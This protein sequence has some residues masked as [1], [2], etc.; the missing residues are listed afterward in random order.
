MLLNFGVA[1]Q[2]QQKIDSRPKDIV[3]GMLGIAPVTGAGQKDEMPSG[4]RGGQRKDFSSCC[5][6]EPSVLCVSV[7]RKSTKRFCQSNFANLTSCQTGHSEQGYAARTL[8]GL[9]SQKGVHLTVA[10][11]NRKLIRS[12]L[13]DLFVP[14][15]NRNYSSWNFH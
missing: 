2:R 11:V 15:H 4:K 13:P 10:K 1:A 8:C 7:I 14:T 3:T 12:D 6:G 5:L 9:R